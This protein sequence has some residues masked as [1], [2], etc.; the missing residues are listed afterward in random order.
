MFENAA[1]YDVRFAVNLGE[2]RRDMGLLRG[3]WARTTGAMSTE[4]LRAAVAQ[5][6]LD[7][8]L[9]RNG[10]D[11]LAARKATLAYRQEMQAIASQAGHT[12]TALAGEEHS[13]GRVAKG[14]I[15]GSGALGSLRRAAVFAS[16]S[17]LGGYGLVYAIRSTVEAAKEQEVALAHLDQALRTTGDTS[18]AVQR[19][20]RAGIAELRRAS[21][22]TDNE[23]TESLAAFIRRYGDVNQALRANAI[24]A[25]VAR[26]K[27][28]SLA[29]AQTLV[30]RASFGNPRSLRI[31]GIELTKTT[32][33]TDRL[34]QTTA[35]ASAAQ[36]AAAKAADQ[37]ANEVAALDAVQTKYHGSLQRFL[38]TSA[39][40]QATFNADLT[41]AK[42][43]IGAGLLPQLNVY[44]ERG[45]KWLT[46]MTD[47][48]RLQRDV[49]HLLSDGETVVHDIGHAFDLARGLV[50]GFDAALGH[51]GD[52]LHLLV[53]L[54][55]ANK[56]LGFAKAFG[57]D[58]LPIL[59]TTIGAGQQTRA[60]LIGIGTGGRT[61]AASLE[62]SFAGV[63]G[64]IDSVK[65]RVMQL[66]AQIDALHGKTVIVNVDENVVGTGAG[67]GGGGGG[68]PPIIAPGRGGGLFG[69]GRGRSGVVD[70]ISRYTGQ[71]AANAEGA[72]A[73]GA[74]LL[75]GT[76]GLLGSIAVV[77]LG[78]IPDKGSTQSI[79]GF[80]DLNVQAHW[81]ADGS[82]FL[83]SYIDPVSRKRHFPTRFF[84]KNTS[85]SDIAT[86]IRAEL[87]AKYPFLSKKAAA[88]EQRGVDSPTRQ[89]GG[90]PAP[91]TR[92]GG[93]GGGS[94]V[95]GLSYQEQNALLRA[96]ATPGSGDDRRVLEHQL[97][98]LNRALGQKGLTPAQVNALLGSRNDALSQIG[99]IDDTNKQAAAEAERKRRDAAKKAIAAEQHARRKHIE[100]LTEVPAELR[101]EEANATAHNASA[102]RLVA[103]YE[104]EKKALERQVAQLRAIGASKDDIA[105]L[106]EHE[107]QIERKIDAASKKKKTD[108]RANVNEFLQAFESVLS[109]NGPN[110]FAPPAA[111]T[112]RP[113]PDVHFHYQAPTPDL[114]REARQAKLAVQLAFE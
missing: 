43:I 53:G 98:I 64:E 66:Q 62:G 107:A 14:A 60:S 20:A 74:G 87:Q 52:T 2:A 111:S 37:Q 90:A 34:K 86:F 56:V 1:S 21:G 73:R 46:Q 101:I 31:L 49:N 83:I 23:I 69:R 89:F 84:D 15:A 106:R 72:A 19:Q 97:G 51:S 22:F 38:T 47:S 63:G 33:N 77:S 78:T 36:I 7:R 80:G 103:I 65:A 100:R 113:V 25:D 93:G 68:L 110:Y 11:S 3:E 67:A 13:L 57:S 48:G 5:E 85:K 4:S 59:R 95:L 92:T 27:N 108:S 91:H 82:F 105:K 104:Q 6:K 50:H 96:Q 32:A 39:G 10:S 61:A 79:T 71:G 88:T 9:A 55:I 112:A 76:L 58:L 30:M 29:D 42:E 54:L 26:A 12:S 114:Q 102:Q 35:H 18:V 41:R 40:K 44:L 8:A 70:R 81:A 16:S 28:I 24:A 17:F 94:L 109:E 75:G 99:S 45:D